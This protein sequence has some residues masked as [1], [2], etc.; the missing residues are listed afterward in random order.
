MKIG[1]DLFATNTHRIVPVFFS[2]G[3][4]GY[5]ENDSQ[6]YYGFATLPGYVP[7]SCNI[8]TKEQLIKR[9]C[10][11]KSDSPSFSQMKD[12]IITNL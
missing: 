2:K 6:L 1:E 9:L 8:G 4:I 7:V 10:E 11:I 5:K 3:D 12:W